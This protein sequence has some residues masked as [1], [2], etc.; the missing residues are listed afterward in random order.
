MGKCNQKQYRIIYDNIVKVAS[1]L[2]V[3]S[4]NLASPSMKSDYI[5]KILSTL[6]SK[7]DNW[8]KLKFI[9]H[10]NGHLLKVGPGACEVYPRRNEPN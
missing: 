9:P 2:L 1:K 7:Q 10:L 5:S 8:V 3:S 4:E 6:L